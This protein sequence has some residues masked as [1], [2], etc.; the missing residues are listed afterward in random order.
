MRMG[1]AALILVAGIAVLALFVGRSVRAGGGDFH[2]D[3][4]AAAPETYVHQGAGEGN[5]VAPGALQFD[6]REINTQVR[7]SLMAED[8]AC[9]DRVVFF[10]EVTVD[11]GAS[12]PQSAELNYEFEAQNH[13]QAGVGYSQVLAAGISNVDFAGQTQE[14]GNVLSG[15][16]SVSLISQ[17]FDPSGNAPPAGFGT[18]A[19]DNLAFT[20]RVTGLEGGEVA[21]VRIDARF[22]CF[23][24]DPT[25]N[26]HAAID[27]A[28]VIAG[29][30]GRI[31][32]GRQTVPMRGLGDVG[33]AAT[34]TPAPT[35]TPAE[36]T[37]TPVPATNTPQQPTAT[38]TPV[39]EVSPTAQAPTA[40]PDGCKGFKMG[41]VN[42]FKARPSDQNQVNAIDAA[43]VL[44]FDAR[45][46][47]H[48]N[49]PELADVN[50][51]GEV[52]SIDALLILQRIA[53]L[54]THLPV[55]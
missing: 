7:E 32:V 12:G 39:S 11:D 27:A 4:I 34:E 25:G 29:G 21:V 49:C 44:Q 40:T 45:K 28:E 51:D 22:A 53:G 43:L 33:G 10:T 52:N 5:E 24:A 55:R 16:E 38:R 15:N 46:I 31:N 36:A 37:H 9:G 30:Q 8:F 23:A 13:G 18:G 20:V 14:A 2:L 35:N 17:S 3:F 19:A 1:A 42:V 47:N 6:D 50:L 26:L 48:L 41:D 54:I